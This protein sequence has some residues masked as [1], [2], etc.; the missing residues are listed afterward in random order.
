MYICIYI[1]IYI[2]TYNV[3]QHHILYYIIILPE[4]AQ[5]DAVPRLAMAGLLETVS[6]AGKSVIVSTGSPPPR[7]KN[8]CP[9]GGVAFCAREALGRRGGGLRPPF[10]VH[11]GG[12]SVGAQGQIPLRHLDVE[13]RPVP[14]LLVLGP[15]RP[16][17]QHERE[18]PG[19]SDGS[20]RAARKVR[21]CVSEQKV[22]FDRASAQ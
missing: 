15:G 4:R 3:M 8:P 20:K 9:S 6:R 19:R 7:A 2:Y 10:R 1:Y 5:V 17:L 18:L 12:R 22:S 11:L 13:G 14:A 16:R 21:G